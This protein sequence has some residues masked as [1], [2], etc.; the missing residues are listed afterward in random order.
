MMPSGM[1]VPLR[2]LIN[3]LDSPPT[4]SDA[5]LSQILVVAA[6]YVQQDMQITTYTFDF[7]AYTITPDPTATDTLNDTF[8]NLTVLKATCLMDQSELRT[9]SAVLGVRAMLGPMSLDT[10]ARNPGGLI[11]A[12]KNGACAVYAEMLSQYNFGNVD[13]IKAIMS[14]FSHN[15]FD[16]RISSMTRSDGRDDEY[17][18]Q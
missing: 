18:Q 1:L 13:I 6:R 7:S 12:I 14:P 4:F 5:R 15:Q 2:V 16:P 10:T 9:Q 11:A 3:D 17:F 8:S